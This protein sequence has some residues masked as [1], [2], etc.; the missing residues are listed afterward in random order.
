MLG[1]RDY[2][3]HSPIK[4]KLIL[5]TM[6]VLALTTFLLS[7][8]FMVYDIFNYR[9]MLV[10]EISLTSKITG[11]RALSS[12]LFQQPEKAS[13]DLQE[14]EA[15]PS[16][17]LACFYD[18][19]GKFFAQYSA[20]EG[21]HACPQAAPALGTDFTFSTLTVHQDIYSKFSTSAEGSIYVLSD[22][23]EIYDHLILY[24]F[25][26]M[27]IVCCVI[28]IGYFLS[29]Q[30]Q[31]IISEPVEDL[32]K[33]AKKARR[34]DDY[35]MRAQHYYDDEIGLLTR[36][37]NQLMV[38]VQDGRENL[39][40]KVY[41]RTRELEREKS[42]AEEANRAK[43]EFL[44]NM[45]HEFRTP[46][47]AM[48]AYSTFGLSDTEGEGQEDLHGYF[49]KIA[50]VTQRLTLLV[51]SLLAVA[52]LESGKQKFKM[53]PKD[54]RS[55]INAVIVEQQS[56]LDKKEIS[57]NLKLP[58]S[59]AKAQYDENKVIQV[60]INILGNAIKFTDNGKTIT[61]ALTKTKMDDKKKK[62]A[63]KIAISDQGVGI[64]DNEIKSIFGKFVQSSRTNTGAG[65]TGLGLAIARKLVKGHSG[66]IYAENNKDGG[67]SFIIILPVEQARAVKHVKV[68]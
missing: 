6:L 2:I 15:K 53:E 60:L 40:Q 35:S 54:L 12:L 22:L 14:L 43:S 21:I 1:I 49:G 4:T 37:F 45:S 39:E 25:V 36:T 18:A 26:V 29:L 9:Q 46:L 24:V 7:S 55:T 38:A 64:P 58:K 32:S 28:A 50:Q 66:K 5:L 3:Y 47:H 67:A 48:K 19:K 10:N 41:E 11:K 23:R 20:D 8:A 62:E 34:N 57:L 61:I 33:T 68:I 59:V 16:I 52:Q 42:K 13:R 31:R 51:E 30:L 56:L 44:R 27:G 65:G 17:R 63:Y